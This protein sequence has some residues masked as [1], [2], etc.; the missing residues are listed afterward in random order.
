MINKLIGFLTIIGTWLIAEYLFGGVVLNSSLLSSGFIG[1]GVFFISLILELINCKDEALK[2]L[3]STSYFIIFLIIVFNILYCT[4]HLHLNFIF[5]I[6]IN[7]LLVFNLFI[8]VQKIRKKLY[9]K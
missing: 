1:A 2:R 8:L 6:V 5:V 7:F 4:G 9:T 3:K